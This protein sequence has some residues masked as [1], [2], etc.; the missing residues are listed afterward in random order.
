[1]MAADMS[2]DTDLEF[3]LKIMALT[4]WAE[5]RGEPELGQRAVA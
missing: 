3:D 1:M 4:V 5:A 2:R